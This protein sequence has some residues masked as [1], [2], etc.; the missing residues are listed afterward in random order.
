MASAEGAGRVNS[1]SNSGRSATTV[2]SSGISSPRG[3]SNNAA[4]RS[5]VAGAPPT[6][7]NTPSKRLRLQPGDR[8]LSRSDVRVCS[9]RA[10][11]VQSLG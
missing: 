1:S 6:A 4:S 10:G 7:V 2:V 9:Q 3:P 8:Q 11:S 5:V